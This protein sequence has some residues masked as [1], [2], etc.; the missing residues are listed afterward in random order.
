[1]KLDEKLWAVGGGAGAQWRAVH[2]RRTLDARARLREAVRRLRG[3]AP[4]AVRRAGLDGSA[5]FLLSAR[6]PKAERALGHPAV[7]YW[8]SLWESHFARACP[9]EDWR[10]HWGQ[11]GGAAAALALETGAALDA[12]AELDPDG[13]L[14]LYGTPWALDVPKRARA[15]VRLRVRGKILR[16]EA[17]GLRATL[18]LDSPPAAP[19]R[20]LDEVA[21][22]IVV[23]DRGWLQLHGVTMHG[24]ARLDDAA[25]AAFARTIARAMSDMAERD[26]LLHAEMIDLLRVLAPLENP[27]NYGSVSSSYA[28]LRGLIALS[29]SDDA[30][31]QA[32]TLIHEFCHMKINQLSAADPL[33]F[34]GQSG[35]VF[36]SPWRPDARRL[37]GLLL[38]A[39][40]FL[41]VA[42]YLARSLER[43]EFDE[44]RRLAVMSNVAR[45]VFQVEAALSA[46]AEHAD[47]TEFGRRLLLE[48]WRELGLVRHAMLWFPA[49]LVAEQ[50]GL[51][52]AHRRERTVFGTWIH[53][54]PEFVDAAPRPRFT[55]TATPARAQGKK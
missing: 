19:W 9:A 7:D 49:K 2:R 21:P 27:K 3:Q 47:F 44:T 10:L 38:G 46:C 45:R 37:R 16:V 54:S 55:T 33:I 40:A 23:D 43:E 25:R 24:R 48:M 22:G 34:P 35:Q 20:R 31:L 42:R 17:P 36:Y 51:C 6:G 32:E 15:A 11:L 29:P 52:D 14:Y 50:R 41:N 53:K 1:M 18:A 5:R 39:H 12:A 8:L 30:L 28:N 4:A 26:P 13:S